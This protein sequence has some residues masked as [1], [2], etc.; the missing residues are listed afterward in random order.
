MQADEMTASNGKDAP[1]SGS[2]TSSPLAHVD[3]KAWLHVLGAFLVFVNIWGLPSCFAVFQSFYALQYLPQYSSSAISWIGTVQGA[4]LILLG[5]LS[6]PLFDLGYYRLLLYTGS[7]LTVVG[8]MTLSLSTE[9]YQVLLSQGVCVGLGCGM[10]YIPTLS[11][12]GDTFKTKRAVAMGLVTSGI[13]LGGVIYTIVFDRLISKLGFPWTVRVIGFICLGTYALAIPTLSSR[14]N[15]PR[16]ARKLFDSTVFKD[17]PFIC[18]ALA[19]FF[20]FL[21]YLVPLFYIPTYAETVLNTN[22]SLA[23]YLLVICQ[24]ASLLGRLTASFPTQYFGVMLVWVMCCIISST[25][26]FT[27]IA[28]DSLGAFIAFCVLYGYFSGALIALPPTIFPILC[29][30]PGTLGSRMGLSWTT[31]AISFLVGAPAAGA[32]IDIQTA[33]FLGLQ[34]WSGVTL[35]VGA[36]FLITLWVNLSRKEGKLLI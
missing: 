12:V 21:G 30:D 34:V 25:L 6:G 16:H 28:S 23:L 13:A 18:F 15:M 26:C 5:L 7:L 22:K 4:L 2:P 35:V 1:A 14:P 32:L 24:A 20:I 10:L 19:Q 31:S 36:V 8:M 9:Y 33:N 11:L 3:S 29:P 17:I 27:W